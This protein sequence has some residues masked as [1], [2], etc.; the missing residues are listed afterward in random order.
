VSFDIRTLA[1]RRHEEGSF[2]KT[3]WTKAFES[4]RQTLKLTETD[5]QILE[6]LA[7]SAPSP[8]QFTIMTR[9]IYQYTKSQAHGEQISA[10]ILDIVNGSAFSLTDWIES[11]NFFYAW[12]NERKRKIDFVSM[13]QYLE[14][15][16]A[17]QDAKQPGITLQ[18]LLQDMLNV[19]GYE[20]G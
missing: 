10:L 8:Q 20:A 6:Y 2:D 18:T 4:A 5:A 13:L 15:C 19:H 14:C 9:L 11:I 17:A 16:V 12:L 3:D 1:D 7:I